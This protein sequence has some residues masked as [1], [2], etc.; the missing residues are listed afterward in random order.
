MIP[1]FSAENKQKTKANDFWSSASF[2]AEA[3]FRY[4]QK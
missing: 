3:R 4:P 2:H 1:L